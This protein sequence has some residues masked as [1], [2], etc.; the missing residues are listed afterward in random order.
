M[1]VADY[2]S[3]LEENLSFEFQ[4]MYT[5]LQERY[6]ALRSILKEQQE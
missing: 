3:K 4:S 5:A 1:V 2:Y 6:N